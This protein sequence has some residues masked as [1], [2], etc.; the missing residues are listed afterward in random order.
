MKLKP[1]VHF[2]KSWYVLLLMAREGYGGNADWTN[3]VPKN[4]LTLMRKS[5]ISL[6]PP[7]WVSS[8]HK[9]I[10]NYR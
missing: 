6:S 3:P 9:W 4:Y 7:G 2:H 10:N 1:T 5:L 8:H